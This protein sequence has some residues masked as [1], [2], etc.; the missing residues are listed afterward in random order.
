MDH[1]EKQNHAFHERVLRYQEKSISP[2]ELLQLN[3]ELRES[4]ERRAEFVQICQGMQPAPEFRRRHKTQCHGW[5]TSGSLAAASTY[6]GCQPSSASLGG[7]QNHS[8]QVGALQRPV[9]RLDGGQKRRIELESSMSHH[10]SRPRTG[11][12]LMRERDHGEEGVEEEVAERERVTDSEEQTYEDAEKCKKRRAAEERTWKTKR[13]KKRHHLANNW[14]NQA[15]TWLVMH[16]AA[17]G[18]KLAGNIQH[19][20]NLPTK[21]AAVSGVARQAKSG[22]ETSLA[23]GCPSKPRFVSSSRALTIAVLLT[24]L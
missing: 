19:G 5:K 23:R 21:T 4:S 14:K 8:S 3:E 1:Q 6:E 22:G 10:D 16:T 7:M 15:D 17:P 12:T 13:Q 18:L 9:Y 11:G 2:E 20:L 24:P